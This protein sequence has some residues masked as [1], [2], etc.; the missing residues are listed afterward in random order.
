VPPYTFCESAMHRFNFFTAPIR[1]GD[2]ILE[3]YFNI[4]RTYVANALINVVESL[5]MK[6]FMYKIRSRLSFGDHYIDTRH[7]F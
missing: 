2:Q 3:A 5:E 7:K 1:Q 6:H 4:G